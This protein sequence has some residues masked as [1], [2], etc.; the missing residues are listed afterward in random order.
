MSARLPSVDELEESD[1][2]RQAGDAG[3]LAPLGVLFRAAGIEAGR[4]KADCSQN[5][6]APGTM[7]RALWYV[8]WHS[9]SGQPQT[10]AVAGPE[11][12]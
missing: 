1:L 10:T 4:N 9:S 12:T 5:P 11:G 7:R 8:G 3:P 2:V 6:Y